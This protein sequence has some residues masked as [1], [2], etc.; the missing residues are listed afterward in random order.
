MKSL[1]RT[2]HE[3]VEFLEHRWEKVINPRKYSAAWQT[4]ISK[5]IATAAIISKLAVNFSHLTG[6]ER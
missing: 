4:P 6:S 5:F 3:V 2:I 1:I